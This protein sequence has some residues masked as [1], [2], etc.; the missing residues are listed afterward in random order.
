MTME[1]EEG[2]RASSRHLRGSSIL[3]VGRFI[4][5]A[6]G[7]ATEVMLVR[8]LSKAD[9]GAVVYA[10]S[11]ASAGSTIALLGLDKV[12]GRFIAIYEERAEWGRVA[13]ALIFMFGTIVVMGTSIVLLI[14]ASQIL[15]AGG[16]VDDSNAQVLLS[17]VAVL[18]PIQALS[19]FQTSLL[20]V[21][22]S[23]SAIFVRRY[24]LA[25][26]LDFVVVLL[27]ILLRADAR[28]VAA[29]YVVAEALGLVVFSVVI[30]RALIDRGVLV[31]ARGRGISMPIREIVSFTLPVLS[32]DLLFILRIPLLVV[33]LEALG[34]STDVADFRAVVP[35][36]RQNLLLYQSFALL[37]TP[38]VARLFARG[39]IR[40]I[41][42]VYW[43]SAVWIALGSFPIF[44]ASFALAQPIAV[45][46]FGRAYAGSGLIL[47]LLSLGC[48][49]TAALGYNGLTLR[50][51]GRVRYILAVNVTT[52]VALV[53]ASLAL[54]SA[55]GVKGAAI[56]FCGSLIV[57]NV[58]YQL[59]LARIAL[60]DVFQLRYL[61]L[62]GTIAL[63]T[64][65]LTAIQ[66][67]LAP[68]LIVGIALVAAVSLFV[69]WVN[70]TAMNVAD[71]FPEVLRV[72]L[73]R[74]F[75]G[76]PG[77]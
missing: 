40:A 26:G 15:F 39:D 51:L 17:I 1:G 2:A 23:P 62:Y 57:Q 3:T 58:L 6:I 60:F 49:F 42:E 46:L 67:L 12:V 55:F 16:N 24:L 34:S 13:G 65:G 48:Y 36:A 68:P 53:P 10:L 69:L 19:S 33:L 4:S 76:E 73:L 22:A 52:A 44:V 11:I 14:Y 5:L 64:V 75:L 38:I 41:N 27:L 29:G 7:L 37:F 30:A 18:V 32:S 70:R 43:R 74:R 66:L 25:P 35:I 61:N 20:A 28:F 21:F 47:A 63:G 71:T 59:G 50:I 56:A 77:A 9:Y 54:I 72:P 8:Y 31:H 45:L